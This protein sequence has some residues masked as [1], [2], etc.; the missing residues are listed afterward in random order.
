[1]TLNDTFFS[2]ANG[3]DRLRREGTLDRPVVTVERVCMG[4]G[5]MED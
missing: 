3:S 2:E 5:K 1:M 4:L